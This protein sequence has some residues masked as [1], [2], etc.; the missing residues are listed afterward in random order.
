MPRST[1]PEYP[2]ATYH[3]SAR[4]VHQGAIFIDDRDR[5]SL[6]MILARALQAHESKAF[7]YCLMGNHYQFVL[8]TRQGNLSDLMQRVNSLYGLTFNRRHCRSGHVFDGRFKALPVDRD[9][10][11]LKVCRYVELNPVRAALVESPARWPWSSHRAHIGSVSSP[12]WLDTAE[13]HRALMGQVPMD[14]VH[15]EAARR[16]YA[17]WVDAGRGVRLWNESL[18][19]GLYVCDK[20]FGKRLEGTGE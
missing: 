4:G 5:E 14:D 7:A 15:T 19:H 1:R 17:D 20:A 16:R 11:L 13:L 18:R 8:Q 9:A 12:H 3:V 6:L 2:G 10:S